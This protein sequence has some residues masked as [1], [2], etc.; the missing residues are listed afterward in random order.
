MSGTASVS[1][2]CF[3]RKNTDTRVETMEGRKSPVM[4]GST[5]ICP[6]IH[7]IVVVTSPMGVQAPP[8]L[9]AMTIMAPKSFLS[10]T[11]GRSFFTSETITM[12]VV[13]LSRMPERK[14]D[15]RA[16]IRIRPRLLSALMTSVMTLK[17][18]CAST[19]STIVMAPRMKYTTS[20]T[21]EIFSPSA[22]RL[23]A[24]VAPVDA[25]APAKM[26][27]NATDMSRAMPPLLNS[28]TVSKIM[29]T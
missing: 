10:S 16:T 29:P 3:S 2:I 5:L 1:G 7:S 15:S 18:L 25:L 24:D 9:A 17:P 4:V 6:L 22:A 19:I 20:L 12:V 8:A 13:R 21:S 11:S 27:H 23:A 26:T 28:K 14:K